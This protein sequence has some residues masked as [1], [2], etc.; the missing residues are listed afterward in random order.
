MIERSHTSKL[1]KV[2]AELIKGQTGL[3]FQT[4]ERLAL[5]L[6][7][8]DP[9][10]TILERN[11]DRGG[12]AFEYEHLDRFEGR[13]VFR[14]LLSMLCQRSLR[15]GELMEVVRRAINHGMDKLKTMLEQAE[16]NWE[17]VLRRLEPPLVTGRP[18]ES[19]H[20]LDAGAIPLISVQIGRSPGHPDLNWTLNREEAGQ[21]NANLA[22]MGVPGTGKSQLLLSLLAQTAR[23]SPRTGFLLL[24]YKGDLRRQTAF[25]QATAAK[26]LD[27]EQE[28]FPLN[29]LHIP[30]GFSPLL[31]PEA[32]ADL[33]RSF[34]PRIGDLQKTLLADT[35]R[36]LVTAGEPLT[37]GRLA[38]RLQER[39]DREN[40]RADLAVTLVR[41]LAELRLFAE[42]E[43]P[44]AEALLRRRLVIDLSRLEGVRELV[45][46]IILHAYQLAVRGLP[47][48][49][50]SPDR[51]CRHLRAIVAV[52][53]AHHYLRRRSPPL[54][55]LVREGRS[56][57]VAVWLASQSPEDFRG[58]PEF[59]ELLGNVFAFRLGQR[60]SLRTI[61]GTFQVDTRQA[62]QLGDQLVS[63]PQYQAITTVAPPAGSRAHQI[64]ILP[65]WDL[66]GFS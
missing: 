10:Q 51:R 56:K 34:Q 62:R 26:V 7:L 57:G 60:P 20:D 17:L 33:F 65:F 29:P 41:R 22:I 4:I 16:Q 47:D 48:A 38:D 30:G 24:D 32:F 2:Q 13:E 21:T 44:P 15:D 18:S 8:R 9:I 58:Q 5:A 3:E 6:A 45:A 59:E 14:S 53:E 61:C 35:Y 11:D 63:L 49:V 28:P 55:K 23:Q 64:T 12:R 42:G 46:F 40:K 31:L 27:L 25:L 37:F 19:G 36:A 54:P 50:W 43:N 1:C 39:Y 52:D 66:K